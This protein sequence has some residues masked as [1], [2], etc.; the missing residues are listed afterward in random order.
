MPPGPGFPPF[1]PNDPL[2][3]MMSLHQSMGLPQ[4]P[5]MPPL[6][7]GNNSEQNRAFAGSPPSKSTERCKDYD[8]KGFCVL[9]STCP[10]QHGSEHVVASDQNDGEYQ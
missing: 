8:T 9:G 3:A 6:P 5:G 7:M 4:M 2:A 10:Y 1:D